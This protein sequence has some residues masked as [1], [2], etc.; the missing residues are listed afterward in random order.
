MRDGQT[1]KAGWSIARRTILPALLAAAHLAAAVPAGAAEVTAQSGF[2]YN[3]WWN[4]GNERASQFF[5]PVSAEC[6]T[7]DF[8]AGLLTAYT[9]THR[10]GG[11]GDSASLTTLVDTKVTTSYAILDRMP[12]DVLL[13]LDFNLPTGKSDLDREDLALVM[14][15]DLVP[16]T[17]FGE[18]FNINPVLS[19]ARSWGPVAAGLGAG[20]LWRGEY[21]LGA[22]APGDE[23][24]PGGVLT[25]SAETRWAFAP[26]WETRLIA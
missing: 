21:D 11:S 6:R 20:Y 3:A 15:P 12:F 8:S 25:L 5:V 24:D 17:E 10:S 19:V 18:G 14:D 13:G 23:Y 1:A 2:E 22:D 4:A 26:T 7:G 16:I 9:Y